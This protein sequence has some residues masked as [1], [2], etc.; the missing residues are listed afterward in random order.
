MSR[1]ISELVRLKLDRAAIPIGEG[2]EQLFTELNPGYMLD[3]ATQAALATLAIAVAEIRGEVEILG[4]HVH[5]DELWWGS[6]AAPN[7]SNACESNVD[8]PF[9]AASGN[10]TWGVGIPVIGSNDR[11]VKPW[12]TEYDLHRI[13]ISGVDN[14]TPWKLRFLYGDQ[15]L[16]EAAAANRY[17]ETMSIA[18]GVGNNIGAGPSE[19]RFPRIP[20][21]WRVWAQ[22]WNFTNLD[23]ISFFAAAHGYPVLE[24]GND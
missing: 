11:P 16:D 5:N 22:A 1:T 17:T 18:S 24:Y 12:Q 14:A 15:S 8:R 10:N 9:T 3:E 21:G 13:A 7:E 6:V 23:T 19:L 2:G 4:Q 20:V